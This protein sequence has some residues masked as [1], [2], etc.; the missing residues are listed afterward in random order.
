MAF[1]SFSP[2]TTIKSA[3]VNS[4]FAAI[5]SGAEVANTAWT[6]WTPTY[7]AGGSMTFGTITTNHAKYIQVGKIVFFTIYFTGTTGGS[8]DPAINFS[9]PVAAKAGVQSNFA[10]AILDGGTALGG[11]ANQS[12][13]GSSTVNCVRYDGAN[14]GLGSGRGALVSGCYPAA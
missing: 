6:D 12:G 1:I 9:L 11:R 8:A 13:S 3:D 2:N 10:A 5:A 4:N 7:S 14:F